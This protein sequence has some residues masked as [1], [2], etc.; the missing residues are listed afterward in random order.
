MKSIQ[1]LHRLRHGNFLTK[2]ARQQET[3]GIGGPFLI[4]E[5]SKLAWQAINLR[6]KVRPD[7]YSKPSSALRMCEGA[8]WEG[9]FPQCAIAYGMQDAADDREVTMTSKFIHTLKVQNRGLAKSTL[10]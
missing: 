6:E 3:K 9:T 5:C 2:T 8:V 1:L 4:P 7:I 10:L